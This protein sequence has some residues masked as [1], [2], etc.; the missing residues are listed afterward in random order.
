MRIRVEGLFARS[1]HVENAST[2]QHQ[3]HLPDA[4]PHPLCR[5]QR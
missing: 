2:L 4:R 5:T 1:Q 3:E